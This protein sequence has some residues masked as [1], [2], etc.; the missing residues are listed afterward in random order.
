MMRASEVI[1]A[2]SARGY[3]IDDR[4]GRV[5]AKAE[6]CHES[7]GNNAP[8]IVIQDGPTD[9]HAYCHSCERKVS[10]EVSMAIGT[11]SAGYAPAR[12]GYDARAQSAAGMAAMMADAY[13]ACAVCKH[14]G[15]LIQGKGDYL[16]CADPRDC[17]GN[18]RAN[19]NLRLQSVGG[20]V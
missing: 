6:I 2:L 11:R 14:P 17:A 16:L 1:A 4:R 7:S 18:C 13:R 8:S 20:L 15:A 12:Q 9:W 19:Q 10:R 3:K 5:Y